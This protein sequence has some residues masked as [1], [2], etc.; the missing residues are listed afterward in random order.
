M[1]VNTEGPAGF[2]GPMGT[3]FVRDPVTQR[4]KHH[5]ENSKVKYYWVGTTQ[6][7]AFVNYSDAMDLDD[8]EDGMDLDDPDG[9]HL[10]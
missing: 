2:S 5:R 6:M 10:D 3:K 1:N 9:M 7:A 8:P 4:L